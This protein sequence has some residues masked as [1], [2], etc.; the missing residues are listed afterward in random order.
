MLR[1]HWITVVVISKI[2]INKKKLKYKIIE[3]AFNFNVC[4]STLTK[5]RVEDE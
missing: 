4:Y 1:R 3:R 5:V 2:A